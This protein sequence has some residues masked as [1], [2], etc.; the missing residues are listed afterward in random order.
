LDDSY[1]QEL[2]GRD[3]YADLRRAGSLVEDFLDVRDDR[4]E[5]RS[6]LLSEYLIQRIFSLE[7][8][9]DACYNIIT[10]STRRKSDRAHRRLSGEL[11][12][13]S[14]LQRLLKFHSGLDGALDAHYVRLSN[15][16]DVNAEPLFW[17]Q[18]A[19]LMKTSGN[20]SSARL[21]LNTGYERARHIDGFK[22]FQLDTQALSIYLL[23]EI[24]SQADA[25][26]GL[27]DLLV[28]IKT[29]SDMITDQSNRQYAIEVIGEV[30]AF[31][32]A[33]LAALKDPEKI[34]LIFELN[35]A[36]Q[37]LASL[38]VEE[39]AYTGSEIVRAKLEVA[40]ATLAT[41]SSKS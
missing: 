39:Q 6:S 28:S 40:T 29:V 16:K 7:N 20:I 4:V 36:I 2:A 8:I 17:L 38:P 31:I 11:M 9:L 27:D 13:F 14:T 24:G 3:V 21:F 41:P 37:G 10:S 30:P 33:R 35:R 12:K 26:E 15:D 22:T 18:Y 32:K 19:I 34:A 25:V 5:M 23:E 1:L